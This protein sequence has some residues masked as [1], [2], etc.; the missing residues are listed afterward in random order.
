MGQMD[1]PCWIQ[2]T[3]RRPRSDIDP[4]TEMLPQPNLKRKP[5]DRSKPEPPAQLKANEAKA[6]ARAL[7]R[8]LSPGIIYEQAGEHFS[9]TAPHSDL[10]RWELQIFDAFGTRSRSI[11]LTFLHQ[12]RR[13]VP[14][15]WIEGAESPK[16]DEVELNA[17]LAM[18]A[19]IQPR[20]I[21]EAAL[22]AQMVAIHWLQMRIAS[23]ACNQF[24]QVTSPQDA[25]LAGKLARTFAIQME[26]LTKLRG[27]QRASRQIIRVRKELHQHVHYHHDRG[28]AQN[29]GQ[30]Q[31]P[32]TATTEQSAS[33]PSPDA[34][35]EVLPR[36]SRNGEACV[37]HARRKG[38]RR[39]QR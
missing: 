2:R 11:V 37:S 22:A 31:A 13:L 24:S 29:D 27:K 35:G 39:A 7:K 5:H 36:P 30:P 32:R 26:M 10:G 8:P 6:S 33:L 23:Q 19:D 34:G 14:D 9:P 3:S 38:L 25:A 20:N 28:D 4:K 16:P 12:L 17:A 21:M 15:V 1:E 18:V